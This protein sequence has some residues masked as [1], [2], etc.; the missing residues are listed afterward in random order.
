MRYG[1]GAQDYAFARKVDDKLMGRA[2]ELAIHVI[3]P[4]HEH[5][6][7]PTVLRAQAMGRDEVL[8]LLPASDRLVRKLLMYK[9]TD[10]Y[11]RQNLASTPQPSVQRILT[12][13]QTQNQL[14]LE[15]LHRL[16]AE[17]LG[18]A[19]IVVNGQKLD[20]S[21]SDGVTRVLQSCQELI[22]RTYPNLRMLRGVLYR[23]EEI[24]LHLHPSPTLYGE[25]GAN[26]SEAEQEMLAAIHTNHRSGLRTTLQALVNRFERKPYGWPLAAIQCTLAR[27]CARGKIEVR[28][29]SNVLEGSALEQ[30][31]H[32]T[33]GFENVLLEPQIDFTA[34]QVRQLKEF[35]GG[36]F[37][38]PPLANKARALALET[39]AAFA[40]LRQR[41][42]TLR[43]QATTFPFLTALDAPL[44]QIE[45]VTGKPY[46]FYLTGLPGRADALFEQKEQVIDPVLRFM[47]GAQK[48]IY[49]SARGYLT[50]HK[51]NLPY[52]SGDEARQLQT[53]LD[54]PHCY[55]G[56]YMNQA[57]SLLDALQAKMAAL[58][59]REQTT[60]LTKVEERWERLAGM[61]EYGDLTDGQRTELRRPFDELQRTLERQT[62]VAVIRDTVRQ[63]D[64]VSYPHQLATMAQWS[65]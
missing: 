55:R 44:A 22:A 6:A 41:L 13:R 33:R 48:E 30:A 2:Q 29:D 8:V 50:A 35:C 42:M 51:A 63:F 4:F 5:A 54:D 20:L 32:N 43:A 15:T 57:K 12:E 60:A 17:L 46:A 56:A 23:E 10:K 47:G 14:R 36:F 18:E 21:S 39:A 34:G 37:D 1:D 38:G 16:I 26:F 45:A 27:L 52:M 24:A 40:E 65:A 25:E 28:L 58:V 31:L 49:L 64:D 53:L 11:V 59:Q 7:N 3:T 61:A 19:T 9:R 62:L